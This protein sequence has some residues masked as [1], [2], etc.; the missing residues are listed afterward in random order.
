MRPPADLALA[1]LALLGHRCA[2]LTH[3][4]EGHQEIVKFGASQACEGQ[5][6]LR[7]VFESSV[8]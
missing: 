7:L 1:G 3:C 4:V 8:S 2:R 6:F 5:E